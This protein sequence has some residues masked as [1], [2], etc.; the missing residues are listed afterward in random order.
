[1]IRGTDPT[2]AVWSQ[3]MVASVLMVA[4][5]PGRTHGLGLITEPLLGDL[6][7]DH[8]TYANLNLWATILGALF[9]FPA[10]TMIDRIGVRRTSA[11]VCLLLAAATWGVSRFT[12]TPAA[13]FLLLLATRALGQ[14]ALSVAAIAAVGKSSSRPGVAMGAFAVLL[15][16]GF[17]V[18]FGIVGWSVRESG[19]RAAWGQVSL[20]VALVGPLAFL[21][22]RE[23]QS[24]SETRHDDLANGHTLRE[25]L[26]TPAFWVFASAAA[27][28]NLVSSGLALFNE[29]V[30]AER[31]FNRETYHTFLVISTLLS[32][33]GQLLCGWLTTRWSLRRLTALSL[34]IY[35]AGLAV[36]A[37]MTTSTGLWAAALLLGLAGGA[38]IVIFFAV[39]PAVFGRAHL[40]HILGAAQLCTV[41][42]SALG[43]VVF[44][45]AQAAT[46]S[47]GPVLGG[48]AA[49]VLVNAV[50]A[51]RITMPIQNPPHRAG[52]RL[53]LS[54]Q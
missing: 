28:F 14:S 15:S 32:L 42:S 18:A 21:T 44:A 30:L 38:I 45:N 11:A 3:V 10:G 9:C 31:G 7:L 12:G 35:A 4:T 27:L 39:W 48:L 20:A 49:V 6:R 29:A 25:T 52:A 53:A 40:G 19:W 43:P 13:L 37:L 46:G 36:I 34:V 41:L 5:L 51:L 22:L 1:L 26:T 50:A 23:L 24:T 8:V 33:L 2:P 54:G 17:A 47:Y 16:L